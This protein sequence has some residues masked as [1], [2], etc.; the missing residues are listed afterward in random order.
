ML[1]RQNRNTAAPK[2]LRT[3]R[4]AFTLLEV[5]VVVAI[6]VMLAGV[7]GYYLMARYEEAKVQRAR[8]DVNTLSDAVETYRLN[9]GDFPAS[10]DMLA[11]MQPNGGMPLIPPDKVMD[12]WGQMYQID[13]TGANNNGLKADVFTTTPQGI[14]I[15]N[16]VQ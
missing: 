2:A 9:N 16:F 13:P 8:I 12:P 14:V 4:T 6:I 10:I 1:A 15:G 5:L 3:T 7:G 11:Q